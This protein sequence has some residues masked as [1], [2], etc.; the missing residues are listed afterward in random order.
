M[1]SKIMIA[2]VLNVLSRRIIELE[3][4]DTDKTGTSFVCSIERMIDLTITCVGILTQ[5]CGCSLKD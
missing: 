2:L 1:R 5:E 3:I 4:D